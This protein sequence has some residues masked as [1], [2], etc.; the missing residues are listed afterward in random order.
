MTEP[1]VKC[2]SDDQMIEVC[3]ALL[4][5]GDK[6]LLA[7]RKLHLDQ[8]GYWEFPG[9]KIEHQESP[10]QCLKRELKEELDLEVNIGNYFADSVFAYAEK[11]IRLS[12]WWAFIE[13]APDLNNLKLTDHSEVQ[14]LTV[15]QLESLYL[16]PADV[17]FIAKLRCTAVNDA[18]KSADD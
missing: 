16:A 4:M 5:Q 13:G 11:T 12:A 2:G 18:W 7:K 17:P 8:G 3:A 6:L 15:D 10:Q 14:W 1:S 9:G